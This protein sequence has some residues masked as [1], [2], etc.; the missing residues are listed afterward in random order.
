MIRTVLKLA[1]RN[2]LRNKKNSIVVILLI[3]VIT[4]IFFIGNS[5]IASSNTGLEQSYID[6]STSDI[7]IEKKTDLTM[8]LY[9][10]NAPIIEN[11]FAIPLLDGPDLILQELQKIDGIESIT[12]QISGTAYLDVLGMRS[13]VLL[14]GI[15]P[16]TY[17]LQFNGIVLEEGS[18]LQAGTYGAMITKERAN[19][20]ESASGVKVKIGDPLLF[21]SAGDTGF[22]I[23]EVPLCGIFSY[24]TKGRFM[25]EIVIADPQTVRILSAVQ[26]ATADVEVSQEAERLLGTE[27]D[28]EDIFSD[29][30]AYDYG[31]AQVEADNFSTVLEN[32]FKTQSDN[33]TVQD[34]SYTTAGSWNF[35]LIRLKPAVNKSTM[36]AKINKL[37]EP[38]GAAAYGWRIA[39]GT[40]AILVLLL[41]MLFN[42]GVF[43]VSVAGVIAIINILLISVFRRTR[44]I[45]TLRAIGAADSYIRS[46]IFSENI[47]L[48]IASGFIGIALGSATLGFINSL[49]LH[50]NNDL[51][52]N[53]FGGEI[54]HI[55]FVRSVAALSVALACLLSVLA[56]IYPV[57]M[58]V[59]I[60]P[61]VAVRQ[62]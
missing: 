7:I 18:F 17:F 15:D 56:S 8:N 26:V 28:L 25:D 51:L 20:I 46:L 16:K 61:I 29:D 31:S 9:G 6:S 22:K 58:A 45:G 14:C 52:A 36:L 5:V 49:N 34:K 43:L 4:A 32:F 3:G 39:A 37:V 27:I 50:I 21:T 2:I 60:N 24:K 55:T 38:F 10:A 23:R 57:E 54:L 35:L 48:A 41:Q 42:A 47:I 40:S 33:H 30:S 13:P 59:K 62:A 11:Y 12:H 19:K 53:L 44:E 1:L